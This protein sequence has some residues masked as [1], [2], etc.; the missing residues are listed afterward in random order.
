MDILA[1]GNTSGTTTGTTGTAQSL[2]QEDFMMLLLTQLQYQD[3]LT[4]MDSTEFTTQLAQFSSID[5]LSDINDTLDNVLMFQE[6]L[7]NAAVAGLIGKS[8]SVEG[9]SVYLNGSA[10][11]EYELLGDA[12]TVTISVMD[13]SGTVVWSKDIGSQDAGT[14]SFTWD[15]TDMNGN[16]LPEGLYTFQVDATAEDGSEVTVTTSSGGVISEV[17]FEDG[18]TYLILEDGRKV[19]LSDIRSIF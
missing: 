18:I 10:E 13:S 2:D 15:G 8:V 16:P 19:L 17:S 14:H 3:P 9:D 12:S 1:I 6:S 4:P 11:L 5:Q 7:Q